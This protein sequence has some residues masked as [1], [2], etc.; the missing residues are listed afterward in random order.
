MPR[1]FAPV[2]APPLSEQ[3][4]S[5]FP[6]AVELMQ[7]LLAPDGCPWDRE[8]TLESL[9]RFVIEEACEVVD[10]I[11]QGD[12]KELCAELGD[13]LFQVVFQA[14][15]ARA[16][17]SFGPDDVI[18]AICDKLVRRH[19]HVFADLSLEGGSAE[20]LQNWERIKAAERA[21]KGGKDKGV[22]GSVAKS[23]PALTRAQRIGE[24][25]ARVGFD[26]PDARGSRAKVTEEL[27]EL[28]AAIASGDKDRMEAELGDA[29]FALVNLSRH[30]DLDA[31]GALRRTIDKFT[32]RFEHVEGRVRE[33]HGGWPAS[34][35]DE[36]LG[37]SELDSYWEEAKRSG[38]G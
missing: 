3:Q 4:G 23:L 1:P 7:R 10:A 32:R 2:V 38:L 24:K 26:W 33:V 37:L 27:G 31:E 22:L 6:R 13:L 34:S 28:D 35:T 8:Q 11:E 12:R 25:V 30:L 5:T 21:A 29:L 20:V 19:P 16:E 18:A 9:R 17:G 15:L 14:E 36:R